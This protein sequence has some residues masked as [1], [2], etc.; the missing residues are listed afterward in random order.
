MYSA[1]TR[2]GRA[3]LG[4]LSTSQV[5]LSGAPQIL[6]SMDVAVSFR[7]LDASGE[8]SPSKTILLYLLNLLGD[9]R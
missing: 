6:I 4:K 8:V 7:N 2:P 1:L 5:R 3:R 9:P